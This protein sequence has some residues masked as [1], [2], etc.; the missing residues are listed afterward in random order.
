MANG[1][2]QRIDPV[3]RDD[4]E[5]HSGGVVLEGDAASIPCIPGVENFSHE[6]GMSA[7]I[8]PSLLRQVKLVGEVSGSL[9]IGGNKGGQGLRLA[10]PQPLVVDKEES[11]AVDNRSAR[12][13]KPN[14]FCL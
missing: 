10:Y 9:R 7:A 3:L 12:S 14:W 5:R 1:Q 6:G 4:I 13:V 11:T 2:C 8:S